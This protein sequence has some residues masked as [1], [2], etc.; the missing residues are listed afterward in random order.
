MPE[1]S[2]GSQSGQTQTDSPFDWA[3][4]SLKNEIRIETEASDRFDAQDQKAL[5]LKSAHAVQGYRRAIEFFQR[6]KELT[7]G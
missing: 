3:I 7:R 1:T 6:Q 4:A 2:A 5:A